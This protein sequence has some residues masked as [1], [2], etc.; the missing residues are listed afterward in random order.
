ML[1]RFLILLGKRDAQFRLLIKNSS[2]VFAA[3]AYYVACV[4]AQS[5]IL[6]RLMGAELYGTYVLIV[7][8]V[9]TIQEFLNPNIDIAL[10][11]FVSEYKTHGQAQKIAAFAKISYW[12]A[13]GFALGSIILFALLLVFPLELWSGY[14]DHRF[15]I[16][17]FAFSRSLLFYDNISM[18][19]LRIFDRFRL[20]SV[21]RV[22][23]ATLEL[24]AVSVVVYTS[25][26]KLTSI[27]IVLTVCNCLGTVVR[28]GAAL[29]ECRSVFNTVPNV[30]ISLL[31]PYWSEIRRF[32]LSTSASR[33]IKVLATRGELLLLGAVSSAQEVAYYAVAK[34]LAYSIWLFADPLLV[35][36]YPQLTSLVSERRFSEVKAMLKRASLMIGMPLLVIWLSVSAFHD[37]IIGTLYGNDYRKAGSCLVVLLMAATISVTLFWLGPLLLSMGKAVLRFQVDL[38]AFSLG[39]IIGLLLAP[40]FGAVGMAIALLSVYLIG[41]STF[42]YVSVREL[43]QGYSV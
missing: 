18:G 36:I 14:K 3:N 43:K 5:V 42:L 12:T 39:V 6:G 27:F 35:A 21:I 22:I 11:K 1:N 8:F 40:T 13:G 38:V 37:G 33:T 23:L 24:L 16:L 10:V 26:S 25:T 31:K 41:H 2:W 29:L 34:K 32:V 9:E 19:L 30:G 28:N 17:A 4:F 15:Y 20:N 7:A